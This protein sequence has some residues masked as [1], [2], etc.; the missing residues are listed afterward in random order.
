MRHPYRRSRLPRL[1]ASTS[2]PRC[3]HSRMKSSSNPLLRHWVISGHWLSLLDHLVSAAGSAQAQRAVAL[4]RVIPG[5]RR[6]PAD[7]IAIGTSE[8]SVRLVK[9]DTLMDINPSFENDSHVVPS[10][11]NETAFANCEKV[12]ERDV[13]IYRKKSQSV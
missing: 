7:A 4:T 6:R 12:V 3:S 9:G 10:P 5:C 2:R 1:L 8:R 13:E 11:R